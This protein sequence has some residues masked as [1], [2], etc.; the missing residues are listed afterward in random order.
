MHSAPPLAR[1]HGFTNDYPSTYCSCKRI[2]VSVILKSVDS[3][4]EAVLASSTPRNPRPAPSQQQTHS[5]ATKTLQH[6]KITGK[7]CVFRCLRHSPLLLAPRG[8]SMTRSFGPRNLEGGSAVHGA[9][10]GFGEMYCFRVL[11]ILHSR[12]GHAHYTL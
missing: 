6:R 7:K 4:V 2:T 5:L 8:L 9:H 3:M 10:E 12:T 11:H 1:P